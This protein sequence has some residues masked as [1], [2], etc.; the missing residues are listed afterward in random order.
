M[1]RSRRFALAVRF[2]VLVHDLGKALTPRAQWPAHHGHEAAS[3][4]LGERLSERLRV[5]LECREL[6]RLVARWHG[7]VHRAGEL[8]PV[9]WLRLFTAA[10]ALRRPER[11]DA[12]VEACECDMLSRPGAPAAYE[13]A[14]RVREAFAAVR[15]VD[16]GAI[17][18][19]AIAR[20]AAGRR[21]AGRRGDCPSGAVGAPE[22]AH[23]VA[24]RATRR[25]AGDACFAPDG[26]RL[27]AR[28]SLRR[29]TAREPL[30]RS[31]AGLVS[32]T[33]SFLHKDEREMTRCIVAA[34]A[35]IRDTRCER[36]RAS[37]HFR[38]PCATRG[39]CCAAIQQETS[40]TGH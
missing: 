38:R 4:R 22:G 12:L 9:T 8:R 37:R 14:L 28:E 1:R 11:L 16:A 39:G 30:R 27:T 33:E 18:T 23:G 19:G 6:G 7:H 25:R 36:R 20:A 40:G 2:A 15:S 26:R 21:D 32:R 17:A 3:V 24:P 13:P 10:D 34:L 5:P 29:L 35:G 31:S